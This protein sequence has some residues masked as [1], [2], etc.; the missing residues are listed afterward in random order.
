[1]TPA[2]EG[3]WCP[4]QLHT[5]VGCAPHPNLEHTDLSY[6]RPAS[7]SL[8]RWGKL[9]L[10]EAKL[11]VMQVWREPPPL[12]W[13]LGP[14]GRATQGA[15]DRLPRPHRHPIITFTSIFSGASL[16]LIVQKP[17]GTPRVKEIRGL[18]WRPRRWLIVAHSPK[19]SL[20]TEAVCSKRSTWSI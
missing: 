16:Q 4:R 14:R 6:Q 17:L 13:S 9:R 15:P 18:S 11:V 20:Q 3:L 5:R 7:E 1:M 8:D 2:Y 10:R 12:A 19:C